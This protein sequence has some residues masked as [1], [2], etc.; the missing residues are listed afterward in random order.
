MSEGN[1]MVLH[2]R[3]YEIESSLKELIQSSE[4]TIRLTKEQY[5]V[6]DFFYEGKVVAYKNSLALLETLNLTGLFTSLIQ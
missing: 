2:Y 3:V 1:L 5:G 4:E 6:H